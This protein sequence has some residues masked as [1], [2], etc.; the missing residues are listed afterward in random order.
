MKPTSPQACP[1]VLR[2]E[3]QTALSMPFAIFDMD[4]TLVDSMPR[5]QRLGRDYLAAK[6]VTGDVE[7]LLK[8][9]VPLTMEESGEL[10]RRECGLPGTGAEI[11]AEMNG[12]MEA[13][14]RR[15]IPLKA[16]VREYLEALRR[17]GASLCAASA[18]AEPLMDACLTR[19]GVAG[20][21]RFLLSCDRVG[22]GKDR[23]DVYLE[24]ARRLGARPGETTVYE[25]AL[26]AARTAKAAGFYVV[27][28]YDESARADWALLTETADAVIRDWR[29]V[30][31]E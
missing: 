6:G 24:A 22:A 14:Y 10:F 21:F 12:I 2:E 20:L 18:T 15:D 23:P 4:G 25:D 26:H 3:L 7:A 17:S 27:G 9:T 5:W 31:R 8:R 11:A 13:H 1:T 16:G 19:L 29:A 30:C 28:V